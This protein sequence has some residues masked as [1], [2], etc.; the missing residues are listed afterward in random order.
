[1]S[2]GAVD[3]LQEYGMETLHV[4][5]VP[6]PVAGTVSVSVKKFVPVVPSAVKTCTLQLNAVSAAVLMVMAIVTVTVPPTTT[7]AFANSASSTVDGRT[8]NI[9]VCGSRL[10]TIPCL[11]SLFEV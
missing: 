10:P 1:M 8:W 3:K 11:V 5:V 9:P 4:L 6:V 2:V 7:V